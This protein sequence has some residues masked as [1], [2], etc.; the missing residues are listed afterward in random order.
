MSANFRINVM[1][2]HVFHYQ[3]IIAQSDLYLIR[4]K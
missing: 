1:Y 4:Y 3:R 2:C